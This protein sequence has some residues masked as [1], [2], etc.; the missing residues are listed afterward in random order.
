MGAF[1]ER[2]AMEKFICYE[3]YWFCDKDY[4]GKLWW[5]MQPNITIFDNK[6]SYT[7]YSDGKR[8]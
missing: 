7:I 2:E 4:F 1:T 3:V 8:N 6:L 5:M